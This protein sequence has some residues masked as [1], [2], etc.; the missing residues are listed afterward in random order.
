MTC[1][2]FGGSFPPAASGGGGGGLLTQGWGGIDGVYNGDALTFTG[3]GFTDI[4]DRGV[5]DALTANGAAGSGKV[6]RAACGQTTAAALV[7][8][9]VGA[10]DTA[11][12]IQ[13]A[14]TGPQVNCSVAGNFA[15]DLGFIQ[16][17]VGD[18][19]WDGAGVERLTV[20]LGTSKIAN[21]TG[22]NLATRGINVNSSYAAPRTNVLSLYCARV[23]TQMVTWIGGAEGWSQVFL[24]T[25]VTANAGSWILRLEQ[26]NA[27]ATMMVDI[28]KWAPH[29]VLTPSLTTPPM[30]SLD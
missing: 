18:G 6:W 7:L 1:D 12:A 28:L 14:I 4:N 17:Q 3:V 15:V 16:S 9:D 10:V 8:E 13:I 20:G 29:G 30:L 22:A 21:G 11:T 26:N 5:G 23:G 24:D 19:Q 25:V 2:R 27:G